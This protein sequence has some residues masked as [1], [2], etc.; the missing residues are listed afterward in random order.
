[1]SLESGVDEQVCDW[2]LSGGVQMQFRLL[3][4]IEE[5]TRSVPLPPKLMD[6]DREHLLET[7]SALGKVGRQLA[8]A[9]QTKAKALA[10][11]FQRQPPTFHIRGVPR[12]H[13]IGESSLQA[14]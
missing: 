12:P 11:S 4:D 5:R 13:I 14:Q 3:D 6:N 2:C 8:T 9:A 10:I 7:L 1:M